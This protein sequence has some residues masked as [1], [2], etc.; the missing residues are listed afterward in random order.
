MKSLRQQVK[1]APKYVIEIV[2]GFYLDAAMT[3]VTQNVSEAL[4]YSVGFDN[5]KIKSQYWSAYFSTAVK[6]KYI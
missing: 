3:N 2:E 6:I 5:E 1:E 4:Q